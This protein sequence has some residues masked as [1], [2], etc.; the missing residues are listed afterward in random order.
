MKKIALILTV[1]LAA[2]FCNNLQAQQKQET[3]PMSAVDVQPAFQGENAG[4]FAKW[5]F[6]QLKYPEQAVK[7]NLTG[8]VIVQFT[9]S[10]TGDVKDI[11]VLRGAHP[12]LDAEAL[13]VISMSPKWT[14]GQVKGEPVNV[15]FVFPVIFNMRNESESVAVFDMEVTPAEFDSPYK[16]EG[17]KRP[18]SVEFTKW[19]FLTMNYPKEAKMNWIMGRAK[20]AFDILEDGTVDNVRIVKSAHPLLDEELVRVVKLSPAWKPATRHDKPVRTTYTL[21]FIFELR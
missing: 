20:V 11:K 5:V 10:K 14:P 4:S 9:I 19:I 12:A 6:T 18:S 16:K 2:T 7:E 15:T 17:E 1:I 8:K 13:R 3:L 21:P